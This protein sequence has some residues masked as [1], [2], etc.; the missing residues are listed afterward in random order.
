[1]TNIFSTRILKLLPGTCLLTALCIDYTANAQFRRDTVFTLAEA[2]VDTRNLPEIRRANPEHFYLSDTFA[3]Q[4]TNKWVKQNTVTARKLAASIA[5]GNNYFPE[6]DELLRHY[7]LPAVYRWIPLSLSG[8]QYNLYGP[9]GRAG[10]WQLP[11]VIA[12]HY[13]LALNRDID[14]RLDPEKNNRT[15]IHYLVD[16]HESFDDSTL[17]LM[18]FFNGEGPVR[19]AL[20][21][22]SAVRFQNEASR[23]NFV[24]EHLPTSTRDDIYLWNYISSILPDHS[25][26]D[27]K[28]SNGLKLASDSVQLEFPVSVSSLARLLNM[29]EKEIMKLNPSLTGHAIPTNGYIYLNK[30]SKDSLIVSMHRL[31]QPTDTIEHAKATQVAARLTPA[32]SGNNVMYTVRQGDNLG[33]I[34][35]Q[36]KVTIR[37]IREW[38]NLK[39]DRI[40]VGQRLVIYTKEKPPERA[41]E[42]PAK[43]AA[44]E[45]GTYV[46]YVVKQGDSLWSISRQFPGVTVD[47]I[48]RW[49]NIGERID[50]GQVLKIRKQ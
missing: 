43:P 35:M 42:N 7:D 37:Q 36:H 39:S 25:P 12:V 29:S 34:A 27:Q 33:R 21:K 6:I 24:Y 17:A 50:I 11:L 9:D 19:S 16:L 38:N 40:N 44:P 15:A 13:G 14:Q 2:S 4:Q 49:N 8:M 45:P 3:L 1:M 41:N 28:H 23:M 10:L 32:E 5:L 31:Q 47:D 30:P 20:K 48:M 22:A 18:A 46:D 26:F